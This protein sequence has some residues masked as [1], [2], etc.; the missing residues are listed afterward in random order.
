MKTT[1]QTQLLTE[2]KPYQRII[3]FT[4]PILIGSLFQQFYNMAD[5]FIISRTLGVDAFAG[6]SSTGGI[7]FL[8][9]GFAQGMTAGLAIPISQSWGAQE[10]DGV[11]TQ[12]MH[13]IVISL[14]TSILLTAVS[15]LCAEW[16][17]QILQ[18]PADIYEYAIEYLRVIFIG[19]FTSM[20]YNFF[21]NTL[22]ALGDSRSPL[23]FL[24]I[25]SGL[26]IILDVV[27]IQFTPLGVSGAAWATVISQG[28][29]ALL[30][31]I[32]I[33][34]R[35]PVL[36]LK[37]YKGGIQRGRILQSLRL[38]LPMAF[39]SSII[40]L[41]VIAMQF[42]TNRMGTIAVAAYAVGSKI[43]GIAVEPLRSLGMTMTTYTA[44]NYGAQK[45]GRI[46]QGVRQSIV[47]AAIL[48]A[49]LGLLMF[50][51]GR[52]FTIL[53]IGAQDTAILDKSHM[54]LIIHGALYM[55]LALLFIF[56]FTLQGLGNAVIPTIAGIMELLMR[57]LAAFILVPY[58]EFNGAAFATPL[59]W[60]GAMLPVMIAYVHAA[61][62]LKRSA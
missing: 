15:L 37:G 2:G 16:F 56:R 5:A 6:V 38:G 50:F 55:I 19:I 30:C 61:G 53:F 3:R 47:I 17:L 54:F 22:R 18:T 28:V 8:I 10:R 21:A 26:N 60:L 58:F 9:L 20:M 4:I 57:L 43:D 27:F 23:Y 14:L 62:K 34:K 7:T 44:Q 51:G 33:L 40:A 48:S 13:N 11:K 1:N 52:L 42:A 59:S 46:R 36:S 24:F 41:G 32:L 45:Y 29:S 12:Y 31:L 39:Q 35:V 49:V 25:A